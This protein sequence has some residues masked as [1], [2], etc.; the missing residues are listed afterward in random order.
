MSC[1][2]HRWLQKDRHVTSSAVKSQTVKTLASK[3]R[4]RALPPQ[5]SEC[6]HPRLPSDA[7]VPHHAIPI[8]EPSA[9]KRAGGSLAGPIV[10]TRLPRSRPQPNFILPPRPLRK[11][12]SPSRIFFSAHLERTNVSSKQWTRADLVIPSPDDA[13]GTRTPRHTDRTRFKERGPARLP[14]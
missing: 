1:L 8:D 7:Y 4:H 3:H 11:L 10:K 13:T 14:A 5:I 2:Q 9:E 12:I 6:R